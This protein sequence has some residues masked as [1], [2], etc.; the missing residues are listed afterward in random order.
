MTYTT[1]SELWALWYQQTA[2]SYISRLEAAWSDIL[3]ADVVFDAETLLVASLEQRVRSVTE[4]VR[5]GFDPVASVDV[6]GLPPL[7]THTGEV[8]VTLQPQETQNAVR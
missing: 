4:L 2:I 6:A 7:L 3:G 8:P 1:T 5:T